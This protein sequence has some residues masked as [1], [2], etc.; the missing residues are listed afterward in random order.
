M[1]HRHGWECSKASCSLL[2]GAV[3]RR[4][5]SF[6]ISGGLHLWLLLTFNGASGV[7]SENW[8]LRK[9]KP[10]MTH[11]ILV[12][13]DLKTA[14]DLIVSFHGENHSQGHLSGSRVEEKGRARAG[15]PDDRISSSSCDSKS[16]FMPHVQPTTVCRHILYPLSYLGH[17]FC[18]LSLSCFLV[19]S[20]IF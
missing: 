16:M 9:S 1:S 18:F 5:Q 13:A 19:T 15:S 6:C 4:S 3:C 11:K 2:A 20:P 10:A 14:V 8:D 7:G 17:P 12:T